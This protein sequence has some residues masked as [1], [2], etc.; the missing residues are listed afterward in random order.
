VRDNSH[1][2]FALMKKFLKCYALGR[3]TLFMSQMSQVER[4]AIQTLLDLRNRIMASDNFPF[5][6][7][8]D[9]AEGGV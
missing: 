1:G 5:E 6:R 3:S 8:S 7:D 4:D 2:C 9:D